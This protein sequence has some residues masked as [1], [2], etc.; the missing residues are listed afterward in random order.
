[1]PVTVVSVLIALVAT[2]WIS[3]RLG[4][5]APGRAIVRNVI[6]G[7]VAMGVTYFVGTLVGR[8]D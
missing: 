2:G 4:G 8:V 1:V 5:A 6:G 7:A 3:S